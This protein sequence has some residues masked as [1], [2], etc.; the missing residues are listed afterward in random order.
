MRALAYMLITLFMLV[1]MDQSERKDFTADFLK[2]VNGEDGRVSTGHSLGDGLEGE[3]TYWIHDGPI[4]LS[5]TRLELN[6]AD[7]V[8]NG[9]ILFN[10]QE[11]SIDE[12][13]EIGRIIK[14]LESDTI[15]FL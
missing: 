15:T 2:T 7:V 14:I 13:I 4:N 8:I 1:S 5:C 6:N 11:V 12:M 9:S 10:S 3:R